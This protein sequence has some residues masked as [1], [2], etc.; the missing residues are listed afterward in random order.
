MFP[1]V[2]LHACLWVSFTTILT[3]QMELTFYL[4]RWCQENSLWSLKLPESLQLQR[5][6]DGPQNFSA[7]LGC[8]FTS[9]SF[10]FHN[11]NIIKWE[12]S[13]LFSFC[14]FSCDLILS[15]WNKL[16]LISCSIIARQPQAM[17]TQHSVS[18]KQ[19]SVIQDI[20]FLIKMNEPGWN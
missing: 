20:F 18:I 8:F 11:L 4:C 3:K 19:F 15:N 9:H 7:N 5:A 2:F 17:K 13:S 12:S 14:H 16:C 6:I 10:W 1:R